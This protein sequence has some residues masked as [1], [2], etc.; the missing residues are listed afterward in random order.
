MYDPLTF[1]SP[2][3]KK[4]V[5]KTERLRKHQVVCEHP[6][7]R[8]ERE[9]SPTTLEK[10]TQNLGSYRFAGQSNA[11]RNGFLRGRYRLDWAYQSLVDLALMRDQQFGCSC[12][13]CWG[14]VSYEEVCIRLTHLSV[15]MFAISL[16][17]C[18]DSLFVL[19]FRRYL[20][21]GHCLN[22]TQTE[23]LR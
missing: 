16:N 15:N 14:A 8:A 6:R 11:I 3:C 1:K 5:V 4:Q 18:Y 7:S 12:A 2:C 10:T 23:P 22:S 9:V 19:Q 21:P 13:V 20:V 17:D